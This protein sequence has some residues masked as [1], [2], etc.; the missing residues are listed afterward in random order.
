MYRVRKARDLGAQRLDGR[1]GD[2][3]PHYMALRAHNNFNDFASLL[4]SATCLRHR[5]AAAVR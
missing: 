4:V 2:M 1:K 5:L 3:V